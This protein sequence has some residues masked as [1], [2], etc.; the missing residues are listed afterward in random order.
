[1]WQHV[2]FSNEAVLVTHNSSGNLTSHVALNCNYSSTLGSFRVLILSF[3]SN[4]SEFLRIKLLFVSVCSAT[5]LS[6]TRFN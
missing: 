5:S 6:H 4:G 2:G 1:M 3:A